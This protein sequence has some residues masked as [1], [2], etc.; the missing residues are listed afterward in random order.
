MNVSRQSLSSLLKRFAA[1]VHYHVKADVTDLESISE[2]PIVGAIP[3]AGAGAKITKDWLANASAPAAGGTFIVTDELMGFDGSLNNAGTVPNASLANMA[4]GTLKG[5]A[6][7]AGT[8]V[9]VN[10][11]AAQGRTLLNVADG[12]NNYVHPNH[13][14]DVTSVADGAQT[15]AND[16]VTNAKLANMAQGSIKGRTPASGTG[17]PE[18]LNLAQTPGTNRVPWIGSAGK[19]TIDWIDPHASQ[20][21]VL[22]CNASQVMVYATVGT[23]EG[24]E[25]IVKGASTAPG[26]FKFTGTTFP[27]T[28]VSGQRCYRTDLKEY[29]VYD[30][31]AAAWLSFTV[32]EIAFGA[33]ASVSSGTFFKQLPLA[34]AANY[35]S[36]YG[37]QFGFDVVVVGMAAIVGASSTCT[38]TVEDD[39][40]DVTN[41]ALSLSSQTNKQ[42]EGMLSSV[43]TAGS[44]IGVKCTSGTATTF[45]SGRVRFRRRLT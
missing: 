25:M 10:L 17:D 14:G 29:F 1:F 31:T 27:A 11:T 34:G 39:G 20:A 35:S 24:L 28:P 33:G 8:G 32:Y 23:T 7:G 38:I 22:I 4:D 26:F 43:I 15:I 41:G 37:E 21:G 5:R 44:I 16:A 18:D 9:P 19:L 40:A 13:S 45:T 42:D 12:A 30:A 2:T 6:L 3:K 36:T